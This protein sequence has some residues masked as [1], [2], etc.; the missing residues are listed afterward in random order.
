MAENSDGKTN[1]VVYLEV[2]LCPP[3]WQLLMENQA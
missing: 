1:N 2:L 3:D